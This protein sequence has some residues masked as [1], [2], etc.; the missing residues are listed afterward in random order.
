MTLVMRKP[1]L[2]NSPSDDGDPGIT[3][4]DSIDLIRYWYHVLE[5][6]VLQNWYFPM[7][8]HHSYMKN[9]TVKI[10][11]TLHLELILILV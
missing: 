6:H 4:N 3:I 10:N 8:R 11:V 9:R 2:F 5:L 7:V 1:A